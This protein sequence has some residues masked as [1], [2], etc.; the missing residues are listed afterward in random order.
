M[1]RPFLTLAVILFGLSAVLGAQ[2]TSITSSGTLPAT[3]TPKQIYYKT[4]TSA[5]FYVC[6]AANTWSLV[7]TAPVSVANGG[8]AAAPGGDDQVFVSSSSSAGAWK[9]LTD[10]NGANQ[11][12]SYTA[13]SNT[14][15]CTSITGGGGGGV[16][17]VTTTGSPASPQ[18]AQISGSTSI[19]GISAAI[20]PQGRL[21]L[22]TATP[23]M[24]SSATAQTTVYYTPA[25]G[26]VVP[27]YDG[28]NW[29]FKTFTELSQ[30]T[31][32]TTK[33][34]AAA[35][36]NSNY[37]LF[38]W[39]DSGTLRCTRGP[40]W[41]SDTA[42]GTGAGTTELE[43]VNGLL[44]NKVAITNGPGAD[45]GTYVGTIH[46][47]GSSQVDL[48]FGGAGAAGG[49]STNLG[50]WNMYNRRFVALI[51]FDNTDSWNYTSTIRVKDGNNANKITFVIGWLG[52]GLT[53]INQTHSQ[54]STANVAAIASIGLNSVATPATGSI[55]GITR[56][57]VSNQSFS[58]TAF[59]TAMAPLGFNYVAPL[60]TSSATG[61]Q[62]WY[63]DNAGVVNLSGFTMTTMF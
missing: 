20:E 28:S 1:R 30:L 27:I 41:T 62:T 24:V 26:N 52:D 10:C 34:P 19:T 61:T 43:Y 12:V 15:G 9:T 14:W 56:N 60:E 4:G 33:S 48:I 59:Y 5:G 38:V 58:T 13:S 16:G 44:M 17:T 40:L 51:N 63:G 54:N 7:P 11:A 22:T 35:T 42:R 18:L 55:T 31:T 2:S 47:N 36:T 50:I 39:S 46:T 45:R 8:T 49:E 57:A 3:C 32:D 37:D 23:W 21:T 25:T 53:A 29:G 6:T